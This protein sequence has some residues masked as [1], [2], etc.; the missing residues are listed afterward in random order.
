MF[1]KLF[2]QI[3]QAYIIF[4]GN[5]LANYSN[6]NPVFNYTEKKL[7]LRKPLTDYI[8]NVGSSSNH[9]FMHLF[10]FLGLHEAI[11][12][13]ESR[14]VP[15]FLII[16]QPSRPY[17][18]DGEKKKEKLDTSDEAKITKAFELINFF[19]ERM[20]KDVKKEFQI[21]VLEH[22][23]P[24]IWEG[25]SHTHLVDTFTLDNALI[26]KKYTMGE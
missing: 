11:Q 18:G 7:T 25:L 19:A 9:M 15:S 20:L 10:F 3:V 17:W 22:V 1:I 24:T 16:D 6:Y 12:R 5:V 4:A 14:F 23:P 13:K 8:E 21:I 2:E 26:P